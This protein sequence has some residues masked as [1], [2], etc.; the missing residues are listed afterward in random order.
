MGYNINEAILMGLRKV[1]QKI[2]HPTIPMLSKEMDADVAAKIIYDKI[3]EGKPLMVS[4]F[5]AVEIS[6]LLN[7]CGIKSQRHNV[8]KFI[9]GQESEWWWNEGTRHCMKYN[10]GFFPNDDES[11]SRFGELMLRCIPDI[12]IL[13]SW[14]PGEVYFKELL[15]KATLVGFIFVD[16]YWS[17]KPWT[18]VL[19][20]KKVLVVHPFAQEIQYQY[21][22]NRTKLFKNP[23][24]LPEFNLKTFQAVQSIGGNTQFQSWFE[25]LKYMEDQIDKEDYDICLLGCGAYGMPLAAHIKETGKQAI[26]FGGSLQL[27]F[28]IRGKRWE[29]NHYG[30]DYFADGIG[31]YPELI[32]E[33]WIRPF[34]SSKFDGSQ[35]VEGGCYW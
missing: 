3:S 10:A 18:K 12:D 21:I 5:G 35:N 9:K 29:T 2:F 1:Y 11:L 14:Q 20:G 15:K 16:P 28:G 27:L 25:A 4:R 6:A 17:K 31:K 34:N 24:I 23:E 30:F 26:H 32:N 19:K 7:Y 22:H 13:L 33:Y 8:W